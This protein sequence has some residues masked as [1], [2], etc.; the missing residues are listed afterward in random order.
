MVNK[1]EEMD[2]IIKRAI[3]PPG[4][5]R[6][7]GPFRTLFTKLDPASTMA[8]YKTQTVKGTAILPM[9]ESIEGV[10]C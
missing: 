8:D 1:K 2:L 10:Q 3:Y 6:S 7:S 4:G 9:I 5:A